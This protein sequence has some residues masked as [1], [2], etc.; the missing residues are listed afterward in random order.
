MKAYRGTKPVVVAGG[1]AGD[2]LGEYMAGGILIVLG[3]DRRQN[4]DIVGYWCGTGMHGGA[5]YVRGEIDP[6]HVASQSAGVREAGEEDLREI[7]PYVDEF[8]HT[9]SFE[10]EELM[11]EP[12]LRIAPISHRPYGA[13]YAA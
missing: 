4:E 10:I 8:C 6:S 1:T 3:L 5:I 2:F 11:S 7:Q 13:K 9:F 12:F